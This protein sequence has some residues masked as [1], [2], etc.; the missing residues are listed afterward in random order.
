M[1][2]FSSGGRWRSRDID[3]LVSVY[4]KTKPQESVAKFWEVVAEEYKGRSTGSVRLKLE[5]MGKHGKSVSKMCKCGRKPVMKGRKLCDLCVSNDVPID[6]LKQGMVHKLYEELGGM[7]EAARI[8]DTS[9]QHLAACRRRGKLPVNMMY[10]MLDIAIMRNPGQ[11]RERDA[12]E[13]LGFYL[14]D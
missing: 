11:W 10:K 14:E 3:R 13:L 6:L 4:N 2:E 1:K 12:R 8:C 5:S 7:S 9:P